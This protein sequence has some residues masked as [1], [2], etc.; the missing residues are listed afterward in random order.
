[1]RDVCVCACMYAMFLLQ[2]LNQMLQE[3]KLKLDENG[4]I[5][6]PQVQNYVEQSSKQH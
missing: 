4:C 5:T 1:M 3:K 2:Q 6:A